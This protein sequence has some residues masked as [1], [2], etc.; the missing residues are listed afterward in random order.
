MT[1]FEPFGGYKVNP[2]FEAC[3]SLKEQYT[4]E[5]IIV[6]EIP[7][8]Y[9]EIK[10]VVTDLIKKHEPHILIMTGQAPVNSITLERIAINI[11]NINNTIYNCGSKPVDEILEPDGKVA[12]FSKL[13]LEK[14]HS[15]LLDSKIPCNLSNHAGTF[16]CNQIFYHAMHYIDENE[17]DIVAGFIH[18]PML[19]KQVMKDT[20]MPL[21][22][23]TAITNAL[24]IALD[25]IING[26]FANER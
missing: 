17:L 3:K 25:I 11:A 4:R 8:R 7:L 21:M 6:T 1:G 24:R 13:P 14:I 12:Y 18:V 2:S 5:K 16:G 20:D 26:R 10:K 23:L 22:K 15:A 9:R 19:P